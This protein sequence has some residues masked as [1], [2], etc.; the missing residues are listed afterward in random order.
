MNFLS[1]TD[2]KSISPYILFGLYYGFITTLPVGPSQILCLR[3]FLLWGNLSGIVSLSG[4]M[5]AQVATTSSIYYSPIYILLSK[6]HLL[7]IVIIPY[8]VVFC[9]TINDLPNYQILRPVTS[10]RDLRLVNLFINSFLFQLLNPVLL[11]TPVLA[12]L[13]HLFLF[14]YSNNLIFIITNFVGWLTGHI[15]FSYLCKFPLSRVKKDSPIIYLLVKRA[16]YTTFSIVFV[17]NA[18]IYLGRAPV[19]FCT[20][21]FMNEPHDKEMAFWEIAEFPDF[22]WWLFKP[23]PTSF[24]DPSRENRGNRFI[25]NNRFDI[26]SSFYKERTS[27]YFFKK[28]LTDGK[29]RLSTTMLPSLSIFEK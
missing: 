17:L 16:I 14:R 25:K 5:L 10:L 22:L 4:S 13:T 12:R 7:T 9:L 6:P 11:P 3:A 23:W 29:Q 15:V 21:K 26:N 27:T 1:L 2:L 18:L 20:V 24:F 8:M 19:S 28:C